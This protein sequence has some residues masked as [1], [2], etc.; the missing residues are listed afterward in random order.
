MALP[1]AYAS[2]M[3]SFGDAAAYVNSN[4]FRAAFIRPNPKPGWGIH[5]LAPS[6]LHLIG[7]DRKWLAEGQ[8]GAF[9]PAHQLLCK[10]APVTVVR[11][12]TTV[13]R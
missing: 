11:D 2:V 3:M 4:A 5:D 6:R 12:R 9:D 8:T 10:N 7:K 1:P 13:V